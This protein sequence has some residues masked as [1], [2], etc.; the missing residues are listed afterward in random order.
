MR[1][2]GF[3]TEWKATFGDAGWNALEKY[4]GPLG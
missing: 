2:S 4:T 1:E 3:Y